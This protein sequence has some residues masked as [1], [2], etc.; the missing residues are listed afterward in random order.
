MAAAG[1]VEEAVQEPRRDS[2]ENNDEPDGH[3]F[4]YSSI[5]IFMRIIGCKHQP[6]DDL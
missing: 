4:A 6:L 1:V 5:V 3:N 2:V